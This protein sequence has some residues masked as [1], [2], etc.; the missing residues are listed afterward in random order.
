MKLLYL[1]FIIQGILMGIDEVFHMKRGLGLWERLG[2]P[3]DSLTVFVPLAYIAINEC[4]SISSTVFIILA[5][6]SCLFI[7]K[8]E[9]VHASECKGIEN[10]LHSMLFILHPVVFLCA[11]LL[12]RDHPEDQFIQFQPLVVGFFMLYQILRWSIPWKP[13]K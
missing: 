10:W 4:I 9:F 13:A 5:T 11:F 6:F 7:T 3:L 1:P 2:H 8:D 12:W